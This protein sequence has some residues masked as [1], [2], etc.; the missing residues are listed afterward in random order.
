M[1]R[2]EG[3]RLT[4]TI[5]CGGL[6]AASFERGVLA[7]SEL[8]AEAYAGTI[9]V[10][11]VAD[12]LAITL[13]VPAAAIEAG[14]VVETDEGFGPLDA[15]DEAPEDGAPPVDAETR[16]NYADEEG[17]AFERRRRCG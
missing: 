11:E 14:P 4:L 10:I 9:E 7:P 15:E 8:A 1:L 2:R 12:G 16:V 17:V 5:A 6:G 3:D 13:T